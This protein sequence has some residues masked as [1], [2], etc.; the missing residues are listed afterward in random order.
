MTTEKK[1]PF[2]PLEWTEFFETKR[3]IT[4]P[5]ALDSTEITFTLYEI[6]GIRRK[7]RS[8]NSSSG[9]SNSSSSGYESD[10]ESEKVKD[11]K[12]LPVILLHHGAGHCAL[13]FAATARELHKLVGKRAR[14]LSYDVRG[15]GE[16]TSKDQLNLNVERLA[17]DVRNVIWTL[18]GGSQD[19]QDSFPETATRTTTVHETKLPKLFLVGHSMGGSVVT[20]VVHQGLVPNVVGFSVLE[21]VEANKSRA[22]VAIRQWCESRPTPCKTV[23]EAIQWAVDADEVR[24][25]ESA[26]VS[27]PGMVVRDPDSSSY[28]WRN[29]LLRSEQHWSSWFDGLNTKFLKS[30]T[31][32]RQM[33]VST[34]QLDNEMKA[35]YEQG[36]FQQLSFLEAGHAVQEDEPVEVAKALIAFVGKDLGL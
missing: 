16:T 2:T 34:S 32:P 1:G 33:I 18:F 31:P 8:S 15:H 27:F 30:K 4:I 13:S 19:G 11:K 36:I 28:L 3:Q 35:G 12:D 5:T 20:E 26:R 29:D 7:R 25:V 24:N 9:N 23:E 14:I 22:H 6:N 10:S 17:M 21:M